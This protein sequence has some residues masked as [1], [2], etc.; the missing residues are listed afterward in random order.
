[1]LE[2][3]YIVWHASHSFADGDAAVE[4]GGSATVV[5]VEVVNS[6]VAFEIFIMLTHGATTFVEYIDVDGV[7][8]H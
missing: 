7:D 2:D 4:F 5:L 8:A 6:F 3:D 1:L